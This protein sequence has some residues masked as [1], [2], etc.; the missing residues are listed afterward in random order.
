MCNC[1]SDSYTKQQY[2]KISKL[3]PD[4]HTFAKVFSPCIERPHGRTFDEVYTILSKTIINHGNNTIKAETHLQLTF[5]DLILTLPTDILS[6]QAIYQFKHKKA[7][8]A[9]N[10]RNRHTDNKFVGIGDDSWVHK[11]FAS[12]L[13]DMQLTHTKANI[14][15]TVL[16]FCRNIKSE[17]GSW[18]NEVIGTLGQFTDKTHFNSRLFA[19]GESIF[20]ELAEQYPGEYNELF[21]A[22]M[23]IEWT[24]T[25]IPNQK[26]Q[27]T[28]KQIKKKKRVK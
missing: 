27:Q 9:L 11:F 12:F 8:I 26:A 17:T 5:I 23:G 24:T 19:I 21:I 10:E 1:S 13:K 16:F 2:E 28:P 18:A 4:S 3:V 6:L 20:I 25:N 7:A 15:D 14:A 22:Y